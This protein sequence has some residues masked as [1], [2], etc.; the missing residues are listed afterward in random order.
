MII[1]NPEKIRGQIRDIVRSEIRV[2]V[3]EVINS[4][5]KVRSSIFMG[6]PTKEDLTAYLD[7]MVRRL[8]IEE[9]QAKAREEAKEYCENTVGTEQFIDKVVARILIK[10]VT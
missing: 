5:G 6:L 9:A 1:L 4:E 3:A 7:R 8:I 2:A 10:Q